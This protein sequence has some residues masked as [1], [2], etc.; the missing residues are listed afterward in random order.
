M[1]PRDS[2]RTGGKGLSLGV[3]LQVAF[4]LLA[5]LFLGG[6]ERD[7]Q[8]LGDIVVAVRLTD[9]RA[10]LGNRLLFRLEHAADY[11]HDIGRVGGRLEALLSHFEA[12]AARDR[13][14]KLLD[15]VAE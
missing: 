6:H 2:S 15:P 11:V 8:I 5:M 14:A 1:L 3:F 12:L 9:N 10:V 4:E 7:G 13:S